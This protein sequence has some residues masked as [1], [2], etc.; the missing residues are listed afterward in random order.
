MSDYNI[1]DF[2]EPETTVGGADVLPEEATPGVVDE[3]IT[4]DDMKL[5]I[6]CEIR[7]NKGIANHHI[8]SMNSFYQT[9]ITQIVTKGFETAGRNRN[10]RDRNEE[11]KSI[12]EITYRVMFTKVRLEQ[13][14]T[15]EYISGSS[16]SLMPNSARLRGLTYACNMYVSAEITA[17]A[18]YRDGGEKVKTATVPDHRIATIPCMVKSIMCNTHLCS[19]ETLKEIEEDPNDSGGYFVINGGEWAVDLL[20]NIRGNTFHVY[21]NAYNNEIARGNFLSKPGDAYE[22]SYQLIIRYY[23]NGAITIEVTTGKFE[24]FEIPFYLLFRAMGMTSDKMIVDSIVH[25]VDLTNEDPVRKKMIQVLDRAFDVEDAQFKPILRENSSNVILEFIANKMMETANSVN[26]KKDDNVIKYQNTTYLGNIDRYILP[27]VGQRNEDRIRKVKFL[28]LLINKLLRVEMGVLESTDRDA[29]PNKRVHGAG[30]SIAKTFKRSFNATVQALKSHYSRAFINSSFSDVRLADVFIDAINV[31]DLGRLLVQSITTGNKVVTVRRTEVTNRISSQM[32]YRKNDLNVKSVLNT[33]TTPG[34]TASKQTARADE[35]RRVHATYTGFID[36]SQST[37]TGEKVGMTKQLGCS[38]SVSEASSSFVIKKALLSDPDLI[39]LD[40]I[41]PADLTVRRLANVFVNGEWIGCCLEAH[42]LARKYRAL[43]RKGLIHPH[44]T[45]VWEISIREISF[46]TDVG[47]LLRPLVIVYNNVEEYCEQVRRGEKAEFKQWIKLTP[48]HIA[49]MRINKLTMGELREMG[50]IEYISPDEQSNAYIAENI[51]VLRKFQNSIE[52]MYTHC[53]VDQ[54]IFGIVTLASPMA[55]HSNAVRNTMYT[56]HRKQSAGWFALNWP[57]LIPKGATLQWYATRPIV[58]A[59]TD[60]IT[61]PNGHNA[62]VALMIHTGFNMEDSTIINKDSVDFGLMNASYFT[63]E[64]SELDKGER[65]ADPDYA[66]TMDIKRDASYEKISNGVIRE[67]VIA[68]KND[69]LIAK[70]A[71][72][73]KP[74]NQYTEIDKSVVHRKDEPMYVERVI[75]PRNEEGVFT[76]KVKLRASRPIGIGDKVS[77]RTGNKGIV[78]KMVPREDMPFTEDG[79]VP[80]IIVNAHS[81]PTRMAVAQII[82]CLMG[83]LAA[84]KGT[85]LDGTSFKEIDIDGIIQELEKHGIKNAG[86]RRMYNG[87][88]GDW[89]DTLIFIG[90]TTYQRLQKF[91]IDEHYATNSGPTNP[92]TMQPLDGKTNDGGLRIGEME[93]WGFGA[94]GTMRALHEKFYDDSDGITVYICRICHNRAVIN[95]R[96]NIYKC[97]YCGDNAEIVAV[98]SSYVANLFWQESGAMNSK[99]Y[100]GIEPHRYP[101]PAEQFTTK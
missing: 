29:Y 80:D 31:E 47:R 32:L 10:K 88:T 40:E 7:D 22:N 76:A 94:A 81:I 37:D 18:H 74:V 51:N 2:I 1:L 46:W 24:K 35:M 67:G 49:Q 36:V 11:D 77:S 3:K 93:A 20:E 39:N 65:F 28:G 27:H 26:V 25:G 68:Q 15:L 5:I 95:E 16:V 21:R 99:M 4:T 14:R 69:V 98:P 84:E 90:P 91:V 78:A 33:V 100:F 75:M 12:S 63:Y 73:T 61:Y 56:N 83:Q 89:L 62:I 30:V 57:Y 96:L 41:S 64:K 48:E 101:V 13:P 87:V 53:D 70:C 34:T 45:I 42:N 38:A 60:N 8:N 66:H 52:H 44:T 19:R 59:F 6:A 23:V 9:G 43:R 92:L 82:E 17:T 54:A 55:N 79:L 72:V 58:T 50:V 85:F 71:K 97:K 86:S